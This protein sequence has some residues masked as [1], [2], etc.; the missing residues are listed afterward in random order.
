VTER[1]EARRRIEK[2]V[3]GLPECGPDERFFEEP[4]ELRAF[5]I[6]VAAYH[7]GHYEWSE[8]QLSLIDAIKRWENGSAGE[9]WSYYER[10]LE[11]LENVLAASGV[12]SDS[13]ALDERTRRIIATPQDANHHQ[14][15]R[16]PVAVSPA[17]R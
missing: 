12:L 16:E 11:A 3:A 13:I 15:R 17:V 6:A 10:W 8:F 2:L 4:W 7:E 5:A 1:G 14:A 9:P